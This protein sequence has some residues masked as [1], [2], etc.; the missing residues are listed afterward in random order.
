MSPLVLHVYIKV[1]IWLVLSRPRSRE[2]YYMYAYLCGS[3]VWCSHIMRMLN[4]LRRTDGQSSDARPISFH[5][6]LLELVR[7]NTLD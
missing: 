5:V 7:S 6:M 4:T 3:T 2:K 1:S